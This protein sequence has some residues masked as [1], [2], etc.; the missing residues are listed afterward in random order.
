MCNICG[1]PD[2]VRCNCTVTQP[3]CDQCGNDNPCDEIVES[4][5][6]YFHL[7][8]D[9]EEGLPNLG[10]PCNSN[11][12]T[13]LKKI[14]AFAIGL[15]GRTLLKIDV[16]ENN[17]TWTKPIGC[18]AILVKTVGGGGGSGGITVGINDDSAAT[19]GGG[20]GGNSVVFIDNAISPIASTEVVVVG[21]GG[22]G[23]NAGNSYIGQPGGSSS[24][25]S[26]TLVGG[27]EGSSPM[28]TDNTPAIGL[29]GLGGT[30]TIVN[31]SWFITGGS[32]EQGNPGIRLSATQIIQGKGGSSIMGGSQRVSGGGDK[33]TPGA[34]AN[35][36]KSSGGL[37]LGAGGQKGIVIIYSF[38]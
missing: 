1:L 31:T 3:Y 21:Q 20:S 29:P 28:Q 6:V 33:L 18:K 2:N 35:G 34:G 14:D 5:C 30:C 38:S 26:F 36:V 25:G 16:F 13:I 12:E 23:G 9:D 7:N 32:G 19:G 11:L 22:S 10:L 15:K 24:F 4:R 37:Q 8:C 17:G 27:G